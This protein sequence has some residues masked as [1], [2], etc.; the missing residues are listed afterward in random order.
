MNTHES[1]GL[2][3]GSAG[4]ARRATIRAGAA[5]VAMAGAAVLASRLRPIE[6]VKVGRSDFDL[7]R[8]VPETFFAWTIDRSVQPIVPRDLQEV[9]DRTYDQTLS[10]TYLRAPGQRVMLSIAYGAS[11]GKGVQTH[12]PEICYPAQGLAI[13][14]EPKEG[15]IDTP[16]GPLRVTRLTAAAGPRVEPITYWIIV[17]G[18]QTTFGLDMKLVQFRRGL[19]GV[20]PDGMLV[21]VSSIDPESTRAFALH[22]RF[23]SEMIESLASGVRQRI[24]GVVA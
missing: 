8:S 22:E 3:P 18:E 24:V 15:A 21:R 6:Q 12:R 5:A 20:V 7:E 17:G 10:R 4:A 23:A 13:V 9:I 16:A 2:A 11:Y 19:R 1:I 14:R